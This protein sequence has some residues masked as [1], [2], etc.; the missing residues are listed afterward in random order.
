MK[1]F[2]IAVLCL[3]VCS[4]CGGDLNEQAQRP[5]QPTATRSERQVSAMAAAK[6]AAARKQAAARKRA[7]ERQRAAAR[8]RAM[9][10]M[11]LRYELRA[12]A[13]HTHELELNGDI[14]AVGGSGGTHT[15]VI[16]TTG[17]ST[18]RSVDGGW[19]VIDNRYTRVLLS[20]DGETAVDI[21]DQDAEAAAVL[22]RMRQRL[23]F[24]ELGNLETVQAGKNPAAALGGGVNQQSANPFGPSFPARAVGPGDRWTS[25]EATGDA[26]N[27]PIVTVRYTFDTWMVEDGDRLA[28][29]RSTWALPK[30]AKSDEGKLVS[31]RGESTI[32]F[33]PKAGRLRSWDGTA[34]MRSAGQL[35][36]VEYELTVEEAR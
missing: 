5:P 34:K 33:D 29:I 28:R 22:E 26:P 10:K 30:G 1:K 23:R 3:L 27:G 25:R 16:D 13:Q 12:G 9:R 8:E 17:V 7:K 21:G 31:G 15:M 19:A 6:K 4:V 24:S 14:R 36:D 20:F 18:V 35:I 11:A 2:T 32:L